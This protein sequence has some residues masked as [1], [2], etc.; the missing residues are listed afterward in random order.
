MSELVRQIDITTV[1]TALCDALARVVFWA[2]N[3][4]FIFGT[5]ATVSVFDLAVGCLVLD[6]V[7]RAFIPWTDEDEDSVLW[8]D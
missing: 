6:T 3:T 5:V 2:K 8:E 4:Y 1:F 7:F